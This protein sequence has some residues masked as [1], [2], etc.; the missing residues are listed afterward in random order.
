MDQWMGKNRAR[1]LDVCIH[2]KHH[3]RPG[4][5]PEGTVT[6]F[7]HQIEINPLV[8]TNIAMGIMGNGPF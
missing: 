5:H 8:M 2:Q 4:V 7:I 6:I 3:P 1:L